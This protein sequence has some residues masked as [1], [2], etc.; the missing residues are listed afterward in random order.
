MKHIQIIQKDSM[1]FISLYW[2]ERRMAFVEF[3]NEDD[4]KRVK[5]YVNTCDLWKGTIQFAKKKHT[6]WMRLYK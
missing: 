5:A 3:Y 2:L 1:P 6:I 4:A